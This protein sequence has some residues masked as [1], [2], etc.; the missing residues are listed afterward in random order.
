[1]GVSKLGSNVQDVHCFE[2][3][4]PKFYEGSCVSVMRC[5][6]SLY[7]YHHLLSVQESPVKK[8][9]T[10]IKKNTDDFEMDIQD[11]DDF[12]ATLSMLNEE[13][14]IQKAKKARIEEPQ[15][16]KSPKKGKV[17]NIFSI[18]GFFCFKMRNQDF[19]F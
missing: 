13:E 1:M 7:T 16:R 14:E 11:D 10:P 5:I 18:K 8:A 3:E 2:C 19:L 6:H 4:D 17:E 9:V 15:A 12:E